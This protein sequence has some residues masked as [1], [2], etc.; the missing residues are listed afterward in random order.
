MM[1]NGKF[2][3]ADRAIHAEL[4]RV[5]RDVDADLAINAAIITGAGTMFSAGGDFGMTQ[6]IMRNFDHR[7]RVWREGSDI[8]YNIINCSKPIVS[9][10]RG[11]AVG[12]GARVRPPG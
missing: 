9:A 11:V 12:G 4:A 7:A 2:N 6:V 1:D 3:T 5:W 10:M 8:V